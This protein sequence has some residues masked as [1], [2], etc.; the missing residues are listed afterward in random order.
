MPHSSI[1]FHAR[2]LR[3][4]SPELR[5]QNAY[6]PFAS[7]NAGRVIRGRA[8]PHF[9]V[10]EPVPTR[11][12][13]TLCYKRFLSKPSYAS[14]L[15]K[16]SQTERD[17]HEPKAGQGIAARSDLLM[18][19]LSA[20]RNTYLRIPGVDTVPFPGRGHSHGED[21]DADERRNSHD[22]QTSVRFRVHVT[23]FIHLSGIAGE[24]PP[25]S[26]SNGF[27]SFFLTHSASGFCSPKHSYTLGHCPFSRE[28]LHTHT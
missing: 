11:E 10:P 28:A 25:H 3:I 14:S 16:Q 4:F 17:R 6:V 2:F 21:D 15:L 8:A 26:D 1:F 13:S 27:H 24:E 9:G 23:S 18:A 12:R 5:A 19:M 20:P 22:N 7:G